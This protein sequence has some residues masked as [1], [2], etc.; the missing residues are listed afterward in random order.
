VVTYKL[1]GGCRERL[2]KIMA[3]KEELQFKKNQAA[4][5][6]AAQVSVGLFSVSVGLFSVSVGLFSVSVGLFS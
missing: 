4:R 2:K 1:S 6:K 5:D 3:Q